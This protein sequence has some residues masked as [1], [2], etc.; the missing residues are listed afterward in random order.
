VQWVIPAAG[1]PRAWGGG[2]HGRAGHAARI[3]W[4][5]PVAAEGGTAAPARQA[6]RGVASFWGGGGGRGAAGAQAALGRQRRAAPSH[7][8]GRP[9]G[10]PRCRG[11][12]RPGRRGP[13]ACGGGDRQDAFRRAAVRAAAVSRRSPVA[14]AAQWRARPGPWAR[15]PRPGVLGPSAGLDPRTQLA[16]PGAIDAA[17][18]RRTPGGQTA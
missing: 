16:Q 17:C 7:G 5:P 14:G 4:A 1:L 2:G 11:G 8:P 3:E 13:R 9:G 18:R 15:C 10:A 6:R 12:A